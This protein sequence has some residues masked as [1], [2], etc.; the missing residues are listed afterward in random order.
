[1][2]NVARCLLALASVGGARGTGILLVVLAAACSS[3]PAPVPTTP[4]FP[5]PTCQID[6]GTTCS[7]VADCPNSTNYIC[8]LSSFCCAFFCNAAADC[9]NDPC[10]AS[11]LGCGCNPSLNG[12]GGGVCVPKPCSADPD[13]NASGIVCKDG[14][15]V[16]VDP[17]GLA[18]SCRIRPGPFA[19]HTGT[20]QRLHLAVFDDAGNA[21][22]LAPETVEWEASDDAG[23]AVGDEVFDLVPSTA[24]G[25]IE[26]RAKVGTTSCE[27]YATVYGP[28]AGG[29]RLVLIDANAGLPISDALVGWSDGRTGN[30]LA[31]IADGG[32]ALGEYTLGPEPSAQDGGIIFLNVFDER[33]AYLSVAVPRSG[34][35]ADAVVFLPQNAPFVPDAGNVVG[36]IAGDFTKEPG[37]LDRGAGEPVNQTG[38]IHIAFSGTA[39]EGPPELSMA[40]VFG[41]FREATVCIGLPPSRN[42]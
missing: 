38:D 39:L 7:T 11:L 30:W 26:I 3:P 5:S 27:A 20:G 31:T 4:V 18:M 16:P 1:M 34:L 37:I 8:D 2:P 25:A 28:P 14:S 10:A 42:P 41:P 33:Y 35:P 6:G 12:I 13:C 36:G 17:P 23:M 32:N 24:F 15:C 29:N 21:Q 22:R 40:E 19:L 9:S